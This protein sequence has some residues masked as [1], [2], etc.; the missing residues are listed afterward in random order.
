M[1]VKNAGS[2]A[3]K[4]A[5]LSSRV[6]KFFRQSENCNIP[7]PLYGRQLI[8]QRFPNTILRDCL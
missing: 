7:R 3:R 4:R 1:C 5:K 2:E 8:D 6:V